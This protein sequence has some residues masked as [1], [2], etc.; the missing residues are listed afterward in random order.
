MF[1]AGFGIPIMAAL[2]AEL[3]LR[4]TSPVT[5]VFI[6]SCVAALVSG[7]IVVTSQSAD[8][9]MIFSA[10]FKNYLGGVLF[11]FY[12]LSIT[13]LAP[14]FGLGNAVFL[15]LLGQLCSAAVI[16][17]FGLMN[18]PIKELGIKRILGLCLMCSGVFL[19]VKS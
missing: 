14:K 2:N 15:V 16:D 10:P 13:A 8:V 9:R 4:L 5:A 19:A 17:H 11:V 6:L 18:L 7:A 1:C 12:I 3:G